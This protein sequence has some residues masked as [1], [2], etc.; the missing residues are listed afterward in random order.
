[1]GKSALCGL[2]TGNKKGKSAIWPAFETM[3]AR[4]FPISP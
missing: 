2:D 3:K 1:M 4:T